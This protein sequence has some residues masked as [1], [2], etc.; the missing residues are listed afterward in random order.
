MGVLPLT[1]RELT[2]GD[3]FLQKIDKHILPQTLEK[4]TFGRYYNQIID[5]GVLPSG[6]KHLFF[7]FG[8]NSELNLIEKISVP[9]GTTV[10]YY[11]N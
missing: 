5:P 1:L 7:K 3:G 9:M 2:F 10:H 4:L 11:N 6:L 8:K